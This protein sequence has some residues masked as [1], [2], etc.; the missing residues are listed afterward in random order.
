MIIGVRAVAK[1]DS[2]MASKSTRSPVHAAFA[3]STRGTGCTLCSALA[4]CL[5]RGL[6]LCKA[7]SRAKSFTGAA[8]ARS[9]DLCVDAGHGPE[10]HP[11]AF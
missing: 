9:D 10:H 7:V 4:V 11:H 3:E 1:V 2:A 5:T 8:I 6:P